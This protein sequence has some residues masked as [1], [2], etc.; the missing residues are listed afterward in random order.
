M[1]RP[2][3]ILA[4]NIWTGW[5]PS[6]SVGKFQGFYQTLRKNKEYQTTFKEENLQCEYMNKKHVF[7]RLANFN[8]LILTY[9]F[10]TSYLTLAGGGYLAM[11]PQSEIQCFESV[12]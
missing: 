7:S 10:K 3:E 2:V 6:P 1:P 8:L 5:G 4:E 11:P 9:D 12:R